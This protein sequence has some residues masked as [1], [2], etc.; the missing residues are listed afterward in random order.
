MEKLNGEATASW[1]EAVVEEEKADCA[2]RE[3]SG[4][5]R[6]VDRQIFG[7]KVVDLFVRGVDQHWRKTR[8][9]EGRDF[10]ECRGA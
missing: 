4:V 6:G 10:C 3:R 7:S 5:D 1:E 9:E 8:R 2:R